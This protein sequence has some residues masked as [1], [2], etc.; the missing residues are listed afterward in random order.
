MEEFR[1]QIIDAGLKPPETLTL[2]ITSGCNLHCRHCLLDSPP[3]DQTTP[4]PVNILKRIAV[5]FSEIGG[6]CLWLTGGEPLTHSDWFEILEFAC[7]QSGLTE[8]GLQTNA[9]LITEKDIEAL[10]SLP[11]EKLALQVSLEGASPDTHDRVRGKGCF[12]AAMK[13]LRLLSAAGLGGCTQVA[14][15]EMR[16]NIHELPTMIQLVQSLGLARL[17]SGTLVEAGRSLLSDEI[18]LPLVSQIQ[19]LIDRYHHD[20]IFRGNYEQVGNVAAIEWFKGRAFTS[21]QVCTCIQTPF[22]N[23]QG[24]MYP[25]V[26]Y[27]NNAL[28]VEGVHERPLKTVITKALPKWA[29]LPKISRR[30]SAELRDCKDCPGRTHCAGGCMGRAHT[31]HGDAMSVE[32]RCHLRRAVYSYHFSLNLRTL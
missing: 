8:V 3:A 21:D 30:R 31:V 10:L 5:E 6:K 18:A 29:E 4:V 16:H 13:G 17:I 7:L 15:T 9:V 14:F 11:L 1:T 32:D 25:C 20:P 24:N 22:I 27:L 26:M 19:D 12:E 2:M 23:A 28:A